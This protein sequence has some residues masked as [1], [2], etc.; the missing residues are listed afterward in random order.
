MRQIF[1]LQSP[2]SVVLVAEHAEGSTRVCE[3]V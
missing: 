1:V 3:E 2:H